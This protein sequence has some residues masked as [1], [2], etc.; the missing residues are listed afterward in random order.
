[1]SETTQPPTLDEV[2]DAAVPETLEEETQEST[3]DVSN[4]GS[5][6][7]TEEESYTR[8]DPKTL[9][10]ELQAMHK[11]LLRDYT[12]KTQSIAQQRKEFE[13][14]QTEFEQ[15]RQQPQTQPQTPQQVPE[16]VSQNM[17]VSEF[18]AYLL[19]QVEQKLNAR[20]QAILEQQE[21][22]YLD[23]AVL[24]FEAT[25]ERLNSQSPA[26]DDNMRTVVGEKL[27]KALHE[28]QQ[29]NGTAI[30]FDYQ[31]RTLELIEKYENDI[32]EKA[33]AIASKKTQ[34]AF[35]GVKRTAPHGGK[36]T[37]A[38]SKPTGSMSLDESID[39][40]FSS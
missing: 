37:Q 19:S 11:S 39:A 15:L 28:Y 26:Y 22:K 27:D 38:P 2:M 17:T 8:I 14:Q 34:E 3:P 23:K 16:G 10:P 1:M 12:K 24:E 6:E 5:V 30:G 9:P 40:A 18:E 31:E 4:E 13:R 29:D 25:D 21:Q 35:R 32:N 7:T 20:E 36:G 33:K